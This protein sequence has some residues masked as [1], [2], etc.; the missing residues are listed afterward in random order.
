MCDYLTTRKSGIVL[1]RYANDIVK[2][3]FRKV[4]H[5]CAVF[6]PFLLKYFYV[7]VLILL[8]VVLILYI[9]AEFLRYKG[10]TVPIFSVITQAAARKR[11]ENKFVLGPVTLTLGIIIAALLFDY[12]SACVGIY[13]LALGDGLASLVGKLFGRNIIPFS[14]G[15]TAEG[16]LAC[17]GAIFISTFLVTKSAFSALIIALI[18]MFIELFP[19]KD[20]DN[21]YIPIIL[22]FVM[23]YLLP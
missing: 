5:L 11:D 8:A 23:Q 22:G 21:L 1:R 20:F 16:S 14:Q 7:P 15:K 9:I 6:I 13:A 3:V 19:L 17:F 10:K 12:K 18:G 4:I 2:E